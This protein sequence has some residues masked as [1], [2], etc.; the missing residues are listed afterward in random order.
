MSVMF[1][2]VCQSIGII[3]EE[4]KKKKKKEI[5]IPPIKGF[6]TK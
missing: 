6:K 5:G 2:T 4:K 3:G 1:H